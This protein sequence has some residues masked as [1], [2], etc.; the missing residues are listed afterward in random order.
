MK[1]FVIQK[2]LGWAHKDGQQ[3]LMH[4]VTYRDSDMLIPGG[5]LIIGEV[6][7]NPD[8]GGPYTD[9]YREEYPRVPREARRAAVK[10][11]QANDRE[12]DR[13]RAEEDWTPQ[14][15]AALP[16]SVH[17]GDEKTYYKKGYIVAFTEDHQAVDAAWEAG[18]R[19]EPGYLYPGFGG[20]DLAGGSIWRA[21]AEHQIRQVTDVA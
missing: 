18:I 5:S 1:T 7:Y 16:N 20:T 13:V 4:L 10:A 8:E 6:N 12:E 11:R 17:V 3:V 2:T 9:W 21:L 15:F 14:R 19:I